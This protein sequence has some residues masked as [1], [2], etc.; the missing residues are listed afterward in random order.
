MDFGHSPISFARLV[1]LGL[2]RFPLF[3]PVIAL[4]TFFWAAAGES[5]G[6]NGGEL[7]AKC[8]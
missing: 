3:F 8:R 7:W 2:P 6:K 1:F 4:T 5:I